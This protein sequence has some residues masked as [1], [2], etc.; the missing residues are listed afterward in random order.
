MK[1]S[2]SPV[3]VGIGGSFRNIGRIDRRLKNYPLDLPH[4]YR[5]DAQDV[6]QIHSYIKDKPAKQRQRI[7][8][9]SRDRADIIVGATFMVNALLD[10]CAIAEVRI[11]GYGLREGI[12]YDYVH[13]HHNFSE[14]VLDFSINNNIKN[15]NLDFRHASTVYRLTFSLFEQLRKICSAE[16]DLSRVIKT[17]A[18]LHDCGVVINYYQ[19]NEHIF[20]TMLNL[21][22]NGLS[23]RELVLSA[24]IAAYHDKKTL[25]QISGFKP[26]LQSRDLSIIR[27]VGVLLRL[28][29]SL[30]RSMSGII[31]ELQVDIQGDDVMVRTSRD[32]DAELEIY[33]ALQHCD[34]FKSIFKKNLFIM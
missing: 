5:L 10:Y 27:Q 17:A 32:Q 26:L 9:L 22:I 18:M 7:K 13:R 30:D 8:G 2:G 29:R 16:E 24:C 19:Q 12:I 14:D 11:S 21:E 28:A 34:E 20:Y 33:D 1:E 6:Q 23:H 4:N 25:I 3:L 31:K 15:Y